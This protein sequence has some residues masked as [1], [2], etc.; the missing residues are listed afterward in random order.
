MDAWVMDALC[1]APR[2]TLCESSGGIAL[3]EMGVESHYKDL[4]VKCSSFLL[5]LPRAFHSK[6]SGA[7]VRE[8]LL[9]GASV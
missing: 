1:C 5:L 7:C 3:G 2:G 6:I 8:Q 4:P 9:V